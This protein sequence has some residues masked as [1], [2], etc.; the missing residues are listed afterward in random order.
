MLNA[1][2]AVNFHQVTSLGCRKPSVLGKPTL[3]PENQKK[4]VEKL[5]V[6]DRKGFMGHK[7]KDTLAACVQWAKHLRPF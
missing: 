4:K 1:T 7:S 2:T 3:I 6:S 5:G